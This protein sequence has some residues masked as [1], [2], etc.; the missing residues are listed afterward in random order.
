MKIPEIKQALVQA[1]KPPAAKRRPL[2]VRGAPGIGKSQAGEQA[3]CALA[4]EMG[5]SFVN[6]VR[7]PWGPHCADAF[8]F[9]TLQATIE[10]PITL[11]GL[12]G[13]DPEDARFAIF[14]AF[15]DKL[16]TCGQGLIEIAE[17]PTAPPLV[18]A[19]LF[20]FFLN[21]KLGAYR[22]PEGWMVY[23]TGNRAID[24]ASVQRMPSPLISRMR[25]VTAETDV[26]AWIAWALDADI[27]PELIAFLNFRSAHPADGIP[28]I[29]HTFDPARGE[30]AYACARTYEMASDTLNEGQSPGIEHELLMGCLGE[31]V[32]TELI[33]FLRVYRDLVNPDAI[34]MDPANAAIP[35]QLSALYAVCG[36]LARKVKADSLDRL[37]VYID[38]LP[39][40]FAVLTMVQVVRRDPT[41]QNNPAYIRFCH[42]YGDIMATG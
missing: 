37:A 1:Y 3:A 28:D 9:M 2:F 11:S 34:L 29:F 5:L 4:D 19:G 40:E 10:D 30:E 42:K 14:K 31:G 27:R 13:N 38:R 6:L 8:C 17:L 20:E 41:L 16:P 33:A 23:A 22:L 18:Q 36:A 7:Q 15:R 12:P 39:A 21:G 26:R 32:G 25:Q 35:A 24:R